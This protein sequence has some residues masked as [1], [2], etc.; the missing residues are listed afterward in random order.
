MR[1]EF[2]IMLDDDYSELLESELEKHLPQR[3]Y[4]VHF[5]DLVQSEPSMVQR[6]TDL[7]IPL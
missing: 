6:C 5:Q 4:P 1:S 3:A 2:P 7:S